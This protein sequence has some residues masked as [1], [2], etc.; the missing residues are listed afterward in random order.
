MDGGQQARGIELGKD[1]GNE[2]PG[3]EDKEE[4]R[5]GPVAP[6]QAARGR[7]AAACFLAQRGMGTL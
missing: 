7:C 2:G 6:R 4:Q 3:Q 5:P 1:R